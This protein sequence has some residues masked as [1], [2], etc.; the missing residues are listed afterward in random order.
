[1]IMTI[2][3]QAG[4]DCVEVHAGHGYL[5]DQFLNDSV[6]WRRDRYGGSRPN[7]C[8]FL[9]ETVEAALQVMGPGG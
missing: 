5:L 3:L 9:F 2:D 1:M 7:R 6:N 4:F 8:R